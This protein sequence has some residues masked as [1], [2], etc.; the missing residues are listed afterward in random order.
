MARPAAHSYGHFQA[1][2]IN[3]PQSTTNIHDITVV[4]PTINSSPM[5]CTAL[6]G[7]RW[8]TMPSTILIVDTG[9]QPIEY[10]ELE[11]S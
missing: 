1:L 3:Q 2:K 5:L 10:V 9:S 7:W 6:K 11:T 4:I 8:Q